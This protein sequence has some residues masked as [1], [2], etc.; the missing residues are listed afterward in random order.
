MSYKQDNGKSLWPFNIGD[1]RFPFTK[2]LGRVSQDVYILKDMGGG[3]S[4][5]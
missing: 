5:L 3:A 1:F 4:E 2:G